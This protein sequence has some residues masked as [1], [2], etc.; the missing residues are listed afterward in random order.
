MHIA[1]RRKRRKR[2][3]RKKQQIFNFKLMKTFK[4]QLNRINKMTL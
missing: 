1:K 2:K 3:R 4:I